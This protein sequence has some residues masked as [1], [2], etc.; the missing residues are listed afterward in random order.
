MRVLLQQQVIAFYVCA[1]VFVLQPGG[2][3]GKR[4]V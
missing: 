4:T 3:G 2:F 1:F